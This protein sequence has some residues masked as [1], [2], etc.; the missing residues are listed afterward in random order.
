[1]PGARWTASFATPMN[2][3]TKRVLV[4]L[5]NECTQ[6]LALRAGQFRGKQVA[7]RVARGYLKLRLTTTIV[8]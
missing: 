6:A 4:S 7:E 2:R 5:M 8:G 3:D 1:M